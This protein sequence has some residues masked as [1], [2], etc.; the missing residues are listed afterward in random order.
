MMP[1]KEFYSVKELAELLGVCEM[2]IYRMMKRGE[3]AYYSIGRAKRFRREDVEAF[4]KRCRTN[5][6]GNDLGEN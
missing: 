2:T 1:E 6:S 4:L 3:I 5:E